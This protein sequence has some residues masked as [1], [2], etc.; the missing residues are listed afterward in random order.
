MQP[1][2]ENNAF[3]PEALHGHATNSITSRKG[4]NGHANGVDEH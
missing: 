4:A 1:H 2:S 3:T